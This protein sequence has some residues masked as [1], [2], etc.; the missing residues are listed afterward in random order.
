MST[1]D[2]VLS[3]TSCRHNCLAPPGHSG[4]TVLFED[5]AAIEVTALIEMF[6]DRGMDGGEFLQGH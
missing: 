1:M 3:N 6:V 5:V 2:P 4:G